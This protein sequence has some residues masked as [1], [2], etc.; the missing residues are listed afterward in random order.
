MTLLA[1]HINSYSRDSLNNNCPFLMARNYLGQK[2]LDSLGLEFVSPDAVLL[3]PELLT[4][5]L[6]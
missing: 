4:Q 3:K 6:R 5:A 2:M 1:N